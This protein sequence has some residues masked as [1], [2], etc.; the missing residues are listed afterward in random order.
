MEP[1]V[2]GACLAMASIALFVGSLFLRA[3]GTYPGMWALGLGWFQMFVVGSVGPFVAFAWLA[4]PLL[5]FSWI[6]VFVR[7]PRWPLPLAAAAFVL[8]GGFM[9]GSVALTSES[10]S[11]E[12][13]GARGAGYALWLASTV[14]AVIAA[15]CARVPAR[16]ARLR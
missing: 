8:A 9:F 12:P 16:P 13:I 10:G 4:N 6:G 3:F 5:L 7:A 11:A 14:C 2:L 1:R 15:A